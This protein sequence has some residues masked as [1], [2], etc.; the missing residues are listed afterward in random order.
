[1]FA[2]GGVDQSAAICRTDLFFFASVYEG[3]GAAGHHE[4]RHRSCLFNRLERCE[5]RS[6]YAPAVS[7]SEQRW[8]QPYAQ[9]WKLLLGYAD[10]HG[11][12]QE[13]SLQFLRHGDVVPYPPD[14]RSHLQRVQRYS[15]RLGI[16]TH[17][18]SAVRPNLAANILR[19]QRS[20]QFRETTIRSAVGDLE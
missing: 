4:L 1:M 7:I 5:C 14:G 15:R 16:P 13:L 18:G 8:V 19:N 3:A 9:R 10:H 6:E 17:H 20:L 12:W 11:L 2:P